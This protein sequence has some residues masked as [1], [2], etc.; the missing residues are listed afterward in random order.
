M[1]I[2]DDATGVRA[3]GTGSAVTGAS[4]DGM[5]PVA[6]VTGAAPL[7]AT[8]DAAVWARV[9]RLAAAAQV[10]VD[11]ATAVPGA[12]A[13]SRAPAVL[14]D[15]ALLPEVLAAGL[16]RRAGVVV[17]AGPASAGEPPDTVPDA[18]WRAAL[19]VGAERVAVGEDSDRVLMQVLG[20]SSLLASDGSSA[21]PGRLVA[22]VSA[23]GGAGGSV[24][25]A[26]VA[27]TAA[28][29][30]QTVVLCDLDPG[31]PGLDI[32]LGAEGLG[33]AHWHDIDA[34]DGWIPVDALLR[35][36]PSVRSGRGAV[37]LLCHGREPGRSAS[38][39]AAVGAVLDSTRRAGVL[40]VLDA[41][42]QLPP[43][44][45]RVVARADL[46]VV[47]APAE[48]RGAV[49]A[50]RLIPQLTASG[51]KVAL[52]V[53]GPSPGGVG[54]ADIA[55]AAGAPLLAAMRPVAALARSIDTGHGLGPRLARPLRHTA[56]RVLAAVGERP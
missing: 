28:R 33:G 42:R 16:P 48:V 2:K 25:A 43:P 9:S 3:G 24:L 39:I 19:T 14:L 26:A 8:T 30:R 7:V 38:E 52:V 53:R 31:G 49:G 10:R 6:A 5:R 1:A 27:L 29:A 47:V 44:V 45:D 13:W 40:T 34:A 32:T 21:A 41:P 54:A 37:S 51:S 17:F 12:G 15:A 20:E 18:V 11:R 50:A 4:A 23:C 35:A 55:S 36:L 22:I 46:T 56:E